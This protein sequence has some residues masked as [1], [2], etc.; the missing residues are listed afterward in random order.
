MK[1]HLLSVVQRAGGTPPGPEA[2]AEIMRRVEAFDDGLRAAGARAADLDEALAWGRRAALAT[3][4]PIEV[5]PFV[6][7]H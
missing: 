7:Q 5:R 4:L 3:T 1:H 6:D 2:L